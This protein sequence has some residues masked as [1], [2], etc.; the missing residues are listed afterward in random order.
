MNRVTAPKMIEL[1]GLAPKMIGLIG[2]VPNFGIGLIGLVHF[3]ND[4]V[5][6]VRHRVN[7]VST[8]KY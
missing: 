5:N 7:R 6:R 2:L 3:Q 4:R 8:K 1:I